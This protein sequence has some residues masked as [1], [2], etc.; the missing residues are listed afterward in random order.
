VAGAAW[1]GSRRVLRAVDG[2]S[3]TVHA[4]EALGIVGESACGKTT[5]GRLLVGLHEPDAG[6][7]RWQGRELKS[8][9]AAERRA[10]SRQ[11]QMVFQDPNASLNP[12]KT[13]RQILEAPLR[14]HGMRSTAQRTARVRELLACV[15][16]DVE[17]L[18]HYP[19]QFSGGQ[20]QRIGIARALVTVP[21]LLVLDEPTSAL[22]VSVQAQVLNLLATLRQSLQLALVLISHDLGAVRWLCDRVAVMYSGPPVS[23]ECG[24]PR[25]G[26]V[27][28]VFQPA[29]RSI[30]TRASP[31]GLRCPAAVPGTCGSA[32]CRWRASLATP[33]PRVAAPS[34]PSLP[35]RAPRRLVA[36]DSHR[37]LRPAGPRR[38]API[39]LGRL[40]IR[41]GHLDIHPTRRITPM[42][43]HALLAAF[44]RRRAAGFLRSRP[45]PRLA[46]GLA[47]FSQ[48]SGRRQDTTGRS[49]RSPDPFFFQ[50]TMDP[51]AR[52]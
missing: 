31:A 34:A 41:P 27:Q 19:H 33:L 32:R 46:L 18:D 16:L 2:A 14:W 49:P 44:D 12:R 40:A 1:R 52:V 48:A 25:A 6:R 38:H 22:D 35:R 37:A 4:G 47:G 36:M 7:I 9:P 20:R 23:C 51:G 50:V 39:T 26:R 8:L 42:S 5:L 21:R 45:G 3:L 28:E 24:G 43:H 15:N 30:R 13:V 11:V 17:A 29:P 10:A